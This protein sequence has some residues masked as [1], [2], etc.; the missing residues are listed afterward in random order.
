MVETFGRYYEDTQ[1]HILD[2]W[3]F[4]SLVTVICAFFDAHS[5]FIQL[6][7]VLRQLNITIIGHCG[8]VF[9]HFCVDVHCY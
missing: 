4:I 5:L 2:N 8:S 3:L 6:E 7:V 9:Y 1:L